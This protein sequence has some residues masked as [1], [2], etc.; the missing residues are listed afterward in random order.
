MTTIAITRTH[1]HALQ[2]VHLWA[3]AVSGVIASL[4][5]GMV[6]MTATWMQG[7]GLFFVPEKIATL[8]LS[9]ANAATALGIITGLGIHIM[10]GAIFGVIFASAYTLVTSSYSVGTAVA[11][12]VLFGFGLWVTNFLIIGPA[13][14]AQL[15]ASFGPELAIPT[16]L[17]FGFALGI[18]ASL[19]KDRQ[20]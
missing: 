3:G 1:G 17:I 19:V 5:M 2:D 18:Y 9:D 15:T 14:G 12:G 4:V 7:D 8:V 11:L 10:L 13:V 20:G 16:H 6:G